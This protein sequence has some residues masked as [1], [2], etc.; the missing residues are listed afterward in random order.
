MIVFCCLGVKGWHNYATLKHWSLKKKKE[1]KIN[2]C[3]KSLCR[4]TKIPWVFYWLCEFCSFAKKL[5][6]I[7]IFF[8]ERGCELP[9]S[10]PSPRLTVAWHDH[11]MAVNVRV[12]ASVGW[13]L[14][15]S[16]FTLKQL[17]SLWLACCSLRAATCCHVSHQI[18]KTK[19]GCSGATVIIRQNV[20]KA[21][22]AIHHKPVT[23]KKK[24][25]VMWR[26]LPCSLLTA[27]KLLIKFSI[28]TCPI[29]P[30]HLHV[31][32][33]GFLRWK[34]SSNH[35]LCAAITVHF[36]PGNGGL[37]DCCHGDEASQHRWS[38]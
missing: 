11:C 9:I 5:I 19:I 15:D 32:S 14:W 6:F 20:Q 23:D 1:L 31:L 30:L 10:P 12:C 21:H 33:A 16:S 34:Q 8:E 29:Q 7:L 18:N 2:K 37:G 4:K 25:D 28:P 13:G 27:L 3:H 38:E 36:H 22:N 24:K 17:A 26:Y 35:R